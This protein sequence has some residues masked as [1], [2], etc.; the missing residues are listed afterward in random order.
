MTALR[1]MAVKNL[2]GLAAAMALAISVPAF[3]QN[4]D[5]PIDVTAAP[6]P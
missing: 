3:A 4:S 1:R 5:A 2:G 6:P